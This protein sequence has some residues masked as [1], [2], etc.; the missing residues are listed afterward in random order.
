MSND[1]CILSVIGYV[2]MY[3]LSSDMLTY[4]VCRLVY[5]YLVSNLHVFSLSS[6]IRRAYI[7]IYIYIWSVIYL[8][9]FGISSPSPDILVK[10]NCT[11]ANSFCDRSTGFS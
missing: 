10:E 3:C 11:E 4:L 5:V 6:E 7:F 8:H 2:Y 1:M 9:V